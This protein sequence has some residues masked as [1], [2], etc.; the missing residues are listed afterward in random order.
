M[1]RPTMS[2]ALN[3]EHLDELTRNYI[4]YMEVQVEKLVIENEKL[5]KKLN[6]PVITMRSAESLKL[7]K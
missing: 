3:Q 6:D 1:K 2:H 4:I 5:K 7:W